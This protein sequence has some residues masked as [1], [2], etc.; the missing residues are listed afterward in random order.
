MYH[1]WINR[2]VCS[3]LSPT[4]V[5]SCEHIYWLWIVAEIWH[6]AITTRPPGE[7]GY[8]VH[9]NSFLVLERAKAISMGHG[10]VYKNT[11]FSRICSPIGLSTAIWYQTQY[12]T[13]CNE[14]KASFDY[15]SRTLLVYEYTNACDRQ[16]DCVKLNNFGLRNIFVNRVIF[17]TLAYQ[18]I[19]LVCPNML[20]LE[21]YM[22]W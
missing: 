16:C 2:F 3:V 7:T 15:N 4:V 22:S 17:I 11:T 5:N 10:K 20:Q 6:I 1:K 13:I 21:Y 19:T 8:R 12:I 14:R 18:S 9:G